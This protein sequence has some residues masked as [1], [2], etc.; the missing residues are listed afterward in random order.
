M[1]SPSPVIPTGSTVLVTGAN[2]FI[3]SHVADQ[4]IKNG[5]KVRGT[6]RDIEKS[7]WLNAYFE[8]TYGKGHF[9]LVSVPDMLAETAYDEV[10]KGVSAFIHTASIVS[11]DP[12]P[13]NV[14]PTAK[15]SALVALKASYKEPSVKRFVL[16][17]SSSTTLAANPETFMKMK[18]AIVTEDTWSPD[19]KELAWTPGPWGPEHGA[20]VYVASKVEQEQAV[21]KYH[22]ENKSKRPDLVVNSGKK[23]LQCELLCFSVSDTNC[24]I[25]PAQHEPGKES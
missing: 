5:Y 1:N 23:S 21:W 11:F 22:E 17:S 13:N 12:D 25:S 9:E 18:G 10:V 8:K 24:H 20:F 7:S 19:A 6:V 15:E 2:G 14:I 4:F 16:T 3:A